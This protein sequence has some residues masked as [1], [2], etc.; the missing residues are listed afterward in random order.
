MKFNVDQRLAFKAM[1][2][3]RESGTMRSKTPDSIW[4][5]PGKATM[6]AFA[7]LLSSVLHAQ[8]VA[9]TEPVKPAARDT[10]GEPWL[11]TTLSEYYGAKDREPSK[12]DR[13][14]SVVC[15]TGG[16]P[17]LTAATKAVLPPEFKD[18]CWI[19][20]SR[21]EPTRQQMKYGCKSGASAEAVTRREADGSFG[22]Q[23]VVNIPEKGAISITRT[24][25]KVP[26]TCD[27]NKAEL[28]VPAPPPKPATPA[29][30]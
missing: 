3:Q 18:E 27:S 5:N 7:L 30:K 6:A 24:M 26:G 25:R 22:S 17:E 19:K 13:K 10:K 15:V 21:D 28:L 20:D 8:A 23:I 2:K 11:S 12:R 4:I 29:T 14:Q 9:K 1:Q 16:A